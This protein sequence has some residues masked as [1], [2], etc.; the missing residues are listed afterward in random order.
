VNIGKLYGPRDEKRVVGIEYRFF[1][2]SPTGWWGEFVTN[3]YKLLKDGEGY[4]IECEDG[5]KG[6]CSIRKRTNRATTGI[7]TLYYY[8]FTGSGRLE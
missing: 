3:E 7:P 5:R 8:Y 6:K 4:V 2:D 1:D